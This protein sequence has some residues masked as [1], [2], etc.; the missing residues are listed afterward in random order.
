MNF[1]GIFLALNNSTIIHNSS[2]YDN[3][4]LGRGKIRET[5]S[6]KNGH[7]QSFYFSPFHRHQGRSSV[8]HTPTRMTYD[9][10]A[11]N[12]YGDTARSIVVNDSER[13]DQLVVV[14]SSTDGDQ[15]SAFNLMGTSTDRH[16]S[17]EK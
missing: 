9:T 3:R 4:C 17:L 14:D 1:R 10:L 16:L 11:P 13:A 12:V 7:P 15:R 6:I 2:K 8:P 5:V